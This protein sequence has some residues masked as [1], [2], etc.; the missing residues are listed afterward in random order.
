[1]GGRKVVVEEG[2]QEQKQE[3]NNKKN[4]DKNQKNK[5]QNSED[6]KSKQYAERKCVTTLVVDTT[7]SPPRVFPDSFQ[8]LKPSAPLKK[9]MHALK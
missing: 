5:N 4:K 3:S 1:M 2:E 6:L 9:R 7:I 8:A